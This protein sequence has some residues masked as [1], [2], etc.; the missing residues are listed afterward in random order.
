MVVQ[1]SV[2]SNVGR[3]A[4]LSVVGCRCH[5]AGRVIEDTV[6]QM[7]MIRVTEPFVARPKVSIPRHLTDGDVDDL[8]IDR[9]LLEL[10]GISL[11]NVSV[12][13]DEAE[14]LLV[15]DSTLTGIV[16]T[17]TSAS[18]IDIVRSTLDQCDLSRATLANIR[19]SRIVG[20]KLVGS[21]LSG[22]TLTDVVF[23]HCSFRYANLRMATLRRVRFDNCVIDDVDAFEA[24]MTDVEFPESSI[25]EFNLDRVSASRVDLRNASSLGL[26]G[27]GNMAGMLVAEEQLPSLAYALAAAAGLDIEA[28][29]DN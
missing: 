21:E 3:R 15:E 26:K 24:S 5:C 11:T 1:T 8:S 20:T 25:S 23:E 6:A 16:L 28:P 10:S 9:G 13:F 27:I 7:A 19:G 2:A 22:A 17:E 4:W 18:S 14:E 29:L 12:L